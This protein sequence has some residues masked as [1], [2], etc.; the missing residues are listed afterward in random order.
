MV[1]NE[2]T[3]SQRRDLG[4][5]YLSLFRQECEGP[6]KE[7]LVCLHFYPRQ[8]SMDDGAQQAVS[9]EESSSFVLFNRPKLLSRSENHEEHLS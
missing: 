4:F 7:R 3:E 6:E 1:D 5:I 8:I 2:G 9:L